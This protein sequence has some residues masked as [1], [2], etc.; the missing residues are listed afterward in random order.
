MLTAKAG[1]VESLS[2]N[3]EKA[4]G[5]SNECLECVPIQQFPVRESSSLF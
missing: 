5:V 1:T 4:G 2:F 3:G